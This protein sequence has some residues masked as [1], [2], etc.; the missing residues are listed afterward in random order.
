M[1]DTTDPGRVTHVA[2]QNT[3]GYS[4]LKAPASRAVAAA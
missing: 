2:L 1:S 3:V 4:F